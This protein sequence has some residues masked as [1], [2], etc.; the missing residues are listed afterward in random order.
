MTLHKLNGMGYD[1]VKIL[2]NGDEYVVY[3]P[4]RVRVQSPPPPTDATYIIRRFTT[5]SPI[6]GTHWSISELYLADT[7]T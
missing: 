4:S 5:G 2:R 7:R 1:S 3:E 6:D